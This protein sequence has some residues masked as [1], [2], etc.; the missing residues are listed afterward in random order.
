[1]GIVGV[2]LATML[3][4]RFVWV[5][6][7]IKIALPQNS[8][9][10]C[11]ASD[12]V[13]EIPLKIENIGISTRKRLFCLRKEKM[14]HNVSIQI[15]S[16]DT[17]LEIL[18]CWRQDTKSEHIFRTPEGYSYVFVPDP[19]H[20]TPPIMTSLAHGEKEYCRLRVKMPRVDGKYKVTFSI[21][22]KDG[23]LAC[24]PIFFYVMTIHLI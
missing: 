23:S 16:H 17:D 24:N 22:S 5:K 3:P 10:I 14:V 12:Q 18:D 4:Y 8:D 6:P 7:D 2:Y 21:S 19:F 1:M 9:V 15:F 20:R 11:S 13:I